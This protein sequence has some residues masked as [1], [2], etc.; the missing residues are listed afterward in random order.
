MKTGEGRGSNPNSRKNL[1]NFKP[2]QSGN[3]K[4][5]VPREFTITHW[6]RQKLMEPHPSDPS[7]TWAQV[8]AAHWVE[9]S[10]T[11]A[12][13]LEELLA[14]MEGKVTQPIGGSGDGSPIRFT[15]VFDGNTD[16]VLIYAALA[17]PQAIRGLVLS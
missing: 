11:S 14:R 2:G 4:G 1:K 5:N 9:R 3:P 10:L 6:A 17:L 16:K 13:Y 15:M 8:I 7:K 12:H